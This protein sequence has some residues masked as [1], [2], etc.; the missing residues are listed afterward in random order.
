MANDMLPVFVVTTSN[1]KFD[2]LSHLSHHTG[3][4]SN[5]NVSLFKLAWE[6]EE[7][8]S[9]NLDFLLD[10]ALNRDIF[11]DIKD[12]FFLI[13]QTSVFLDAKDGEGPGQYFKKWWNTKEEEELRLVFSRNP[14]A[15]IESGLALNVP[16]HEPLIF[17]SKQRGKISLDGHIKEENKKY[18]WLSADDFNKYFIPRGAK[19]VY[20][21]MDINEFYKYDF[22]KDNFEKVSERLGEYSS[23]IRE[24]VNL[25]K[26][27]DK[28]DKYSDQI[29]RTGQVKAKSSV[30]TQSTLDG[31]Y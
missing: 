26:V 19:K 16:G 28:L 6:Y 20:N 25:A 27:N 5:H 15:T 29:E 31:D 3:L 2:H 13:E 7:I 9:D 10:Q 23:I 22:R 8:Q 17:T 11:D 14:G 4:T 24:G 12:T 18:S 1:R 30:P 21:S